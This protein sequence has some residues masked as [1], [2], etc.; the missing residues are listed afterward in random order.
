MSTLEE[1]VSQLEALTLEA[2]PEALQALPA[3]LAKRQALIAQIQEAH[4]AGQPASLEADLKA[5]LQVVLERDAKLLERLVALHAETRRA[6][7]RLRP[8][9]AATRAYRAT[10]AEHVQVIR[11]VG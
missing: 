8:G 6:L 10:V 9:R 11:R 7:E 1:L 3:V 2:Q 5:R 4:L